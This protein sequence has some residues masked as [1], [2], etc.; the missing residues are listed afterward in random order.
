M[1]QPPEPPQPSQLFSSIDRNTQ[2]EPPHKKFKALFEQSDPDRIAQAESRSQTVG[3]ALLSDSQTQAESGGT[4]DKRSKNSLSVVPEEEEESVAGA[5][6]PSETQTRPQGV[7]RKVREGS[8][9]VETDGRESQ[10]PVKRRAE[11]EGS[12]QSQMQAA[13]LDAAMRCSSKAPSLRVFTSVPNDNATQKTMSTSTGTVPDML[14]QDK[15]FLK[16]VASTK[17]GKKREDEFDR[18]FNNLRISKPDLQREEVERE[19]AVLDDFG[20]DRDLKGNFMVVVEMDLFRKD[21]QRGGIVRAGGERM[22]WEGRPDFKKFKKVS[23]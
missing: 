9:D 2:A 7:K 18:E 11:G 20:D 17:R 16:A 4:Q 8:E 3:D 12:A 5:S 23:S 6:V 1:S 10:R 22:D 21:Y 14:D 13:A 19:W 15:A